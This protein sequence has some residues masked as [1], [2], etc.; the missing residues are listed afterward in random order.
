M[1]IENKPK[2]KSEDL[3]YK[4]KNEKGITFHMIPEKDAIYFLQYHNNYTRTCSYR[5]NFQTY[6]RGKNKG[7]YIGLDFAHLKEL[8]ILDMELR[9]LVTRMCSDIEHSLKVKLIYSIEQNNAEDGY[10][11]VYDFLSQ[12]KNL[13]HRIE[14]HKSSYAKQLIQKYFTLDQEGHIIQFNDCPIWILAEILTFGD[15]IKL[16]QFYYEKYQD[17]NDI[18]IEQPL[19]NLVKSLRNAAA[20]NNCLLH[21]L[22]V[23]KNVR[24]PHK[25]SRIFSQIPN[26]NT[27]KLKS[28]LILELSTL[29]YVYSMIVDDGSRKYR[30]AELENFFFGRLEKNKYLFQNNELLS[31]S[32]IYIQHIVRYFIMPE[33]ETT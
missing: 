21:N 9:F 14:Y 28:R 7:K 8:S 20:H 12:N 6:D 3:I 27:K 24:P 16:Y 25:V 1:N 10:A 33:D 11:I 5:K 13:L 22:N 19:L 15:F 23:D 4:M 29:L 31:S 17:T 30:V 26:V 18:Y 2:L 32:C